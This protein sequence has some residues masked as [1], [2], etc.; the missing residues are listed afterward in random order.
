MKLLADTCAFL[1]MAAEPAQL[2]KRARE[3]LI[4]REHTVYLSAV[5]V[6]EIC[7][8]HALGQL[9]LPAGPAVWI[10]EMR[11][12]HELDTLALDELAS[13]RMAEL[14]S[15]HRDPFDRMLVC[16]ALAYDLTV[17]TSDAA[18]PKYGV[19]TLW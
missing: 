7:I 1:W 3:A 15:V 18:F 16:Q 12:R 8:K 6:I 10:P 17:V 5:S 9:S 14:P 11:V 19:K 13:L 4:D 2:S